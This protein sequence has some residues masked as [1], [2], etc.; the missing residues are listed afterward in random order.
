M[1]DPVYVNIPDENLGD[2]QVAAEYAAY[3]VGYISGISGGRNV[4]FL[5]L[6]FFFLLFFLNFLMVQLFSFTFPFIFIFFSFNGFPSFQGPRW[7][8]SPRIP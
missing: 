2:I 5:F 6:F 4:R 3:T 8:S 1:A 7:M